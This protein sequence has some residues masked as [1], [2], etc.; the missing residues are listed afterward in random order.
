[1]ADPSPLFVLLT[2]MRQRW[3]AGD[4]E[5]A[6]ALARFAAPYL[7]GRAAVARPM[8]ELAGVSDDELDGWTGDHGGEAAADASP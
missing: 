1:M 4:Q 3:D 2:V 6:V 7:H 5:G 8:G